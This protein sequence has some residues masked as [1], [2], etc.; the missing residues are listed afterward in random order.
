MATKSGGYTPFRKIEDEELK[1]FNQIIEREIPEGAKHE[2][3]AVATQVVNGTNYAFLCSSKA[4]SPDAQPYNSLVIIHQPRPDVN[5][6]PSLLD[7]KKIE[8]I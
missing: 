4:V 1:L 2:A 3:L 7:I 5:E 6:A 8:I